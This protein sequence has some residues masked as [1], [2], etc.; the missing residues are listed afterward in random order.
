MM[1]HSNAFK[2]A[3]DCLK[4]NIVFS[5]NEKTIEIQCLFADTARTNFPTGLFV[6]HQFLIIY[7]N[8]AQWRRFEDHNN[9][10]A[11]MWNKRKQPAADYAAAG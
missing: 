8:S 1:T 3:L 2:Y 6:R 7:G 10:L 5:I 9:N 4:G 11:C